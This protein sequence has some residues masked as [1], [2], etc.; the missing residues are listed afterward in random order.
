MGCS[1]KNVGLTK[2]VMLRSRRV[3]QSP[4]FM[5][6]EPH[7]PS[8]VRVPRTRA[9]VLRCVYEELKQWTDHWSWRH[10]LEDW[11]RLFV[12]RGGHWGNFHSHQCLRCVGR[13]GR[14]KESIDRRSRRCVVHKRRG[15]SSRHWFHWQRRHSH[16]LNR[17]VVVGTTETVL[18]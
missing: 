6:Q 12:S 16:N 5:V 3:G 17:N 1:G 7:I 2:P 13:G 8:H 14:R 18:T 15:S 9:L 4:T 11:I 10:T